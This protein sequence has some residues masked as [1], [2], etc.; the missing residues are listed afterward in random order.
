[1]TKIIN[2]TPHDVNVV[3]GATFVPDVRKYMGGHV[4]ATFTPEGMLQAHVDVKADGAMGDVPMMRRVVTGIDPVPDDGAMHIVS[5]QYFSAA[6]AA[7]ADTSRLLTVGPVVVD[8]DRR[9]VG[10]VGFVRG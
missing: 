10:T 7:G 1:M 4:I 8:D 6:Q 5:A 2:N 3:V 9:I